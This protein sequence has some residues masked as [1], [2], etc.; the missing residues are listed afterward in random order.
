MINKVFFTIFSLFI[1]IIQVY[2][3]DMFIFK[4]LL[5]IIPIMYFTVKGRWESLNLYNMVV[6]LFYEFFSGS[7]LIGI[8]LIIYLLISDI[9]KF[10][11]KNYGLNFN[12]QALV[13]ITVLLYHSMSKNLFSMSFW[14]SI[15][16]FVL[17]TLGIYYKKNEYRGFNK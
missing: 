15:V 16:M 2:F 11:M 10:L 4:F 6:L 8:Y 12:N 7:N 1:V 13:L 5:L 9:L 17:V 3:F 14:V